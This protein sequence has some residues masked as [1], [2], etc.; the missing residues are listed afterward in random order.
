MASVFLFILEMHRKIKRKSKEAIFLCCK[1]TEGYRTVLRPCE[2]LL[3]HV[4]AMKTP[5]VKFRLKG[6]FIFNSSEC[7]ICF[8]GQ[9][10][11]S[12]LVFNVIMTVRSGQQSKPRS[13]VS[14]HMNGDGLLGEHIF[15]SIK[16]HFALSSLSNLKLFK[17]QNDKCFA[18]EL[19]QAAQ[20]WIQ[21]NHFST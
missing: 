3:D 18:L 12:L 21:P 8:K 7:I 14:Q 6:N 2:Q 16:G 19:F 15:P 20:Q 4:K 17:G 10:I 5:V 9:H 1:R 13:K 11:K